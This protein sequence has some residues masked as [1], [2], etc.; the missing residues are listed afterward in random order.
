[1]GVNASA[2]IVFSAKKDWMP[3]YLGQFGTF[4]FPSG[5]F[6]SNCC[7]AYCVGLSG[8][9]G[10]CIVIRRSDVGEVF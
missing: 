8:V 3:F 1:M 4:M 6:P 9:E 10:E 2:K 7:V 5:V